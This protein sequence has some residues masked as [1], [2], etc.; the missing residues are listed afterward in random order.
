ML[1]EEQFDPATGQTQ[2]VDEGFKRFMRGY[3]K[4][5]IVNTFDVIYSVG[6]LAA[7][8]LGI[9]SSVIGMHEDFSGTAITPFS[10]TNP[11][12]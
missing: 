10:C 1:E 3:R 4:K 12:G 5:F 7:A 6:A 2:R 8:G 9:Y 11:A